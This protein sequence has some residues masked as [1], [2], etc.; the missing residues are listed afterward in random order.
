MRDGIYCPQERMFGTHRIYG[1]SALV[2]ILAGIFCAWAVLRATPEFMRERNN[3][4]AVRISSDYVLVSG[5][6]VSK[7]ETSRSFVAD[8]T[9]PYDSSVPWRAHIQYDDT[10]AND[11][12]LRDAQAGDVLTFSLMRN[13][14]PLSADRVTPSLSSL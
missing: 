10:A 8:V 11:A 3:T 9:G 6:L 13:E 7:D 2:G 12:A 14:G 4:P 1:G 5:T